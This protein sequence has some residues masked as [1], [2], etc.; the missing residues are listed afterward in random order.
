MT[1]ASTEARWLEE[2][3]SESGYAVI[4][5]SS[6]FSSWGATRPYTSACP[7]EPKGG[8]LTL[9]MTS[10]SVGGRGRGRDGDGDEKGIWY[11]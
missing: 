3:S 1:D 2:S 8:G 4:I 11:K 6:L 10:Y 5:V 7:P 9:S